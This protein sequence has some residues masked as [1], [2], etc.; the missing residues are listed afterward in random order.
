MFIPFNNTIKLEAVYVYDSQ[1]VENVHYFI[2][3]E[4]PNV[5]TAISLAAAY[6]DWWNTRLKAAMPNN[7]S[8]TMIKASVMENENDPAVEYTDGLPLVG[9]IGATTLP[10]NCTIAVRWTTAFRGRSY[11]GR[12]Y[13]IGIKNSDCGASRITGAFQTTLLTAYQDL[14]VLTVDVGPA[15]LGVASRVSH[16]APRDTGVIT[17]VSNVFIDTV[18]DSQRRRLPGRGR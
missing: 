18:I 6:K 1:Y 15:V 10:N 2:V 5:D 8:L 9:A 7:L 14:M 11:Q 12:T 4:T 17:P 13:H 16:G 3:D